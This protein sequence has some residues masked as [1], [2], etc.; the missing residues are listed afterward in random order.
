VKRGCDPPVSATDPEAIYRCLVADVCPDS[1]FAVLEIW[2]RARKRGLGPAKEEQFLSRPETAE[3]AKIPTKY[4]R[5][6]FDEQPKLDVALA[7]A[8]E[9]WAK[10]RPRSTARSKPSPQ[11]VVQQFLDSSADDL[12]D[13]SEQITGS[14]GQDVFQSGLCP[15]CL[16]SES[17]CLCE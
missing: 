7:R 6:A 16:N 11:S 17:D 1:P 3:L 13:T 12:T 10:D 14:F 2:K 4:V 5:A 8:L 15:R 9:L